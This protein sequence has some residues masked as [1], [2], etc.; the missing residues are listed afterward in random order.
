M[1]FTFQ[2]DAVVLRSVGSDVQGS[3]LEDK[4]QHQEDEIK[5][6]YVF[7]K[8]KKLRISISCL[9]AVL[10]SVFIINSVS[11]LPRQHSPVP[12]SS[13]A[14]RSSGTAIKVTAHSC[15]TLT[16]RNAEISRPSC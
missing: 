3:I 5:A 6:H 10:L 15:L 12:W 14:R 2:W 7:V 11:N 13:E 1:V 16:R 4:I 8:G 9:Q